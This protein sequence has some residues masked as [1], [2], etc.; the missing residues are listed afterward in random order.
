[1]NYNELTKLM[2]KAGWR[3]HHN[4]KGSHK[5]WAHPDRTYQISV[6]D[7]GS[8][9]MDPGLVRGIKKQAGIE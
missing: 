3:F 6:P 7:H 5:M 4:G 9:E 8:K 2:K 1:M